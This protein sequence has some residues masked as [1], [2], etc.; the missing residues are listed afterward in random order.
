MKTRKISERSKKKIPAFTPPPEH[1]EPWT[2]SGYKRGEEVEL[3]S[4][5]IRFSV[6]WPFLGTMI[7]EE[8]SIT[9]KNFKNK[10]KEE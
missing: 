8:L 9:M 5:E 2:E 3:A 4:Q 6:H 7:L 10:N 1:S